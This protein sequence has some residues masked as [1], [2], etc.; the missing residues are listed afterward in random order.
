[1]MKTT[2][3]IAIA[4][5]VLA[6]S[7][8]PSGGDA[9][10]GPGDLL[11]DQKRAM[12]ASLGANVILPT[13]RDFSAAAGTLETAAGA[14]AAAPSEANRATAQDAWIDAMRI[15]QRA[16]LLSLGP[17]GMSGTTGAV[18]GMNL[19]DQIYS[20]PNTNTC[21]L[22]QETLEQD[23]AD[24]DAFASQLV[25][26]R[27]LGGIEYLLFVASTENTCAATNPVNTD[28]S[29][30]ALGEAEIRARRAAYAHTLAILVKRQ[31]DALLQAWEPEGGDF[32]GELSRAGSGSTLFSTAQRGVNDL[33][34]AM[35]YLDTMTKDM[36]VGEPAG[37]VRCTADTCLD[38]LESPWSRQSKEHVLINLRAFQTLFLGAEPDAEGPGF[39]DLLNAIGANDTAS[40]LTAAIADSIAAVEA[41]EGTLEEAILADPAAVMDAYDAIGVASR[42]F[43]SDVTTLLD[44]ELPANFGDND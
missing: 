37:I 9:D 38:Q 27:G 11:A 34:G 40:A 7:C 25:D 41:L 13:Y 12:L 42:L 36:K 2:G 4:L 33:A 10:A 28:G 8:G 31:A 32:L 5:A 6:T 30:A 18:G 3:W 22:D 21:R 39:D 35:I 44:I 29:W 24:I 23:Y 15:W 43:K 19:R 14:L 26:V 1:M 17:A 20:F 16:E